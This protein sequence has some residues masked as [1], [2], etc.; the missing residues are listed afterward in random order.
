LS[1]KGHALVLYLSPELS[2]ALA[3][4]EAEY[5]LGRS[6][7]GLLAIC[8]GFHT[9]G[10][11][12]DPVYIKLKKR[13]SLKLVEEVKTEESPLD[14]TFKTM[15]NNWDELPPKTRE[16]TLKKARENPENPLA[17]KILEKMGSSGN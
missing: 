7:A 14:R 6:Y 11:L 4:T 16:W 3:K 15:L 1:F 17:K 12:P 5:E 2:L 13:Y 8:E 10:H 9:L